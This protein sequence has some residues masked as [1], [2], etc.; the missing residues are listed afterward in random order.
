MALFP[1]PKNLLPVETDMYSNQV[2][3]HGVNKSGSMAMAMALRAAFNNAN[4]G[5]E[6]QSHYFI[7]G[8]LEAYI[9]TIKDYSE[10][11][12]FL[13]H[14][15]YGAL[16]NHPRRVW[17]TQFRHPVPRILSAYNWLKS[18][19][20]RRSSEPFPSLEDFVE[21]TKGVAHSQVAQFGLGFGRLRQSK[22]RRKLDSSDLYELSRESLERDFPWFGIAEYFDESLFAL[23]SLVGIPGVLPWKR[24]QRNPGR[25]LSHEISEEIRQLIEEV[26]HHDMLLYEFAVDEFLAKVEPLQSDGNFLEYKSLCADQYNDRILIR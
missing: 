19:H 10:P 1:V 18:R 6:F 8:S 14:Y 11:G 3:F 21:K 12:F 9:E 13:G 4:R 17:T 15:L 22:V 20:F 16:S 5:E 26:F 24:D 25:V 2:V 7:G 23:A